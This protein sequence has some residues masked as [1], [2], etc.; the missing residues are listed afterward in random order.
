MLPHRMAVTSQVFR[1][2]RHRQSSA[3]S[4]LVSSRRIALLSSL[5]RISHLA[6]F[7]QQPTKHFLFL[8]SPKDTKPEP[9]TTHFSPSHFFSTSLF[10]IL[11]IS[12]I[13]FIPYERIPDLTIMPFP[14]QRSLPS[15]CQGRILGTPR[16]N[17]SLD[18]NPPSLTKNETKS[19]L[20]ISR[21]TTLQSTLRSPRDNAFTPM[22]R[23]TSPHG[24]MDGWTDDDDETRSLLPQH[25]FDR[26]TLLTL[27]FIFPWSRSILAL[28]S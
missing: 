22:R 8:L 15:S 4:R 24:W 14:S 25:G 5:S 28:Y 18:D 20:S 9:S 27:S 26:H 21:I 10:L 3:A 2:H 17:S 1:R 11:S 23:R 6:S 13:P 19:F 12:F 16:Y 7:I